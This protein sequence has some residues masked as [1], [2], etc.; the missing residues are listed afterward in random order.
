[1]PEVDPLSESE[2]ESAQLDHAHAMRGFARLNWMAERYVLDFRACRAPLLEAPFLSIMGYCQA[3]RQRL[4]EAG[5]DEVEIANREAKAA[6][7][8]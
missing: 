5:A 2:R 8:G 7:D 1:M 4:A 6:S 3:A